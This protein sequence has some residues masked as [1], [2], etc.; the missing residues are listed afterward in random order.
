SPEKPLPR[1][2]SVQID[3]PDN[4]EPWWAR[5][6]VNGLIRR[7]DLGGLDYT[8]DAEKSKLT[9]NFKFSPN[10]S[11][12]ELARLLKEVQYYDDDSP[13]RVAPRIVPRVAPRITR[14]MF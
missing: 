11:Y 12:Q 13:Y 7:L 1:E 2:H 4:L 6:F 10:L 14:R 8:M 9:L 3:L 5:R